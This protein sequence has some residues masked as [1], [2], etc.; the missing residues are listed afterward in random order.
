[1]NTQKIT[2]LAIGTNPSDAV[3][4]DQ[5]SSVSGDKIQNST[6]TAIVT[7][8]SGGNVRIKTNGAGSDL[9]VS[10]INNNYTIANN[11][12]IQLQTNGILTLNAG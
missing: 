10:S 11:N 4:F 5:L 7:A 6:Q 8:E 2:N 1:M 9:V 3:R 12:N